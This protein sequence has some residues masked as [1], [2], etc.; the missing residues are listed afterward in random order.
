[1]LRY[2]AT[3]E[4]AVHRGTRR[5]ERAIRQ[6]GEEYH[7]ARMAAGHSQQH[8]ADRAG[9]S[10]ALCGRIERGQA[11][12]LS[13]VTAAKIAA[14][15]GLDLSVRAYPGA[16]RLRDAAQA[17]RL[18][19]LLDNVR[20]PLRYRT[21]VVL[22]Q[23]PDQP[24]EQRAWDA[25]LLGPGGRTAVELEMRLRDAML[26]G[27]GGRTAVELEMR[28]RDAQAVDRRI[29]L[30]L[31]DDP[32]DGFLLVVADTRANRLA[33]AEQP[34]LFANLLRLRTSSVL[35]KLRAGRHPGSGIVLL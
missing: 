34:G 15:L 19:L 35:G 4:R 2:M 23:R 29:A 11:R 17:K 26:L 16:R 28:L 10:R 25:M 14:V 24:M 9:I 32:V 31:R 13:I 12:D 5:S 21:E 6:L 18:A 27:P 30:K 3:S 7:D 8:V 22:P 20:P 33:L 1:M